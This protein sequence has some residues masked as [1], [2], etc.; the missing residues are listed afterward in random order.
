MVT[1]LLFTLTFVVLFVAFSAVMLTLLLRLAHAHGLDRRYAA[2]SAVSLALLLALTAPVGSVVE[3]WQGA[4]EAFAWSITDPAALVLALSELPTEAE[5]QANVL[6]FV[7]A[8]FF[9]SLLTRRLVPVIGALSG[10]SLM[11]ELVQ[12]VSTER[13]GTVADWAYNTIGAAIGVIAARAY[14]SY[15]SPT[16]TPA[17]VRPSRRRSVSSEAG[18]ASDGP[19]GTRREDSRP[20]P[21]R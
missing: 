15:S 14:R 8:A 12:S 7:P 1:H 19:R 4:A 13:F 5:R 18:A 16:S 2:W 21:W 17:I 10:L 6:L 20:G 11:I 3:D 9:L